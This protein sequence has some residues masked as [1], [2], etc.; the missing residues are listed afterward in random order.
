M[1]S[2]HVTWFCLLQSGE[3]LQ[4]VRPVSCSHREHGQGS[5]GTGRCIPN[6]VWNR[7]YVLPV[8]RPDMQADVWCVELPHGKDES[9]QHCW[10]SE[11]RL[12]QCTSRQNKLFNYRPTINVSGLIC[13]KTESGVFWRQL[14]SETS[15]VIQIFRAKSSRMSISP[16]TCDDVTPSTSW[17]SSYPASWRQCFSSPSFSARLRK[18][19]VIGS[20]NSTIMNRDVTRRF[21]YGFRCRLEW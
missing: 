4:G 8:W 12:V 10:S 9:H 11:P 6:N 3:H 7:H 18:R 15:S 20:I 17:T 16:S 21:C 1:T 14:R 13:R 5:L 2:H 19:Y